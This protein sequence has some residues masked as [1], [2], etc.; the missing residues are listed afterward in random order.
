MVGA[1][2]SGNNAVGAGGANASVGGGGNELDDPNVGL[3]DPPRRP[4][5]GGGGGNNNNNIVRC[6]DSDCELS[7]GICEGQTCAFTCIDDPE[8]VG[9]LDCTEDEVECPDGLNCTV[10]CLDDG[11]CTQEITCP[12]EGTCTIECEEDNTCGAAHQL[13]GHRCVQRHLHRR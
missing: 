11:Q 10:D 8:E 1:A 7:G 6:D 12:N 5:A 2:G 13:R 3:N 4:P 9:E